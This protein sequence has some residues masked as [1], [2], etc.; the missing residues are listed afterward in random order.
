MIQTNINFRKKKIMKETLA[1]INMKANTFY[2]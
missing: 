2:L 1:N